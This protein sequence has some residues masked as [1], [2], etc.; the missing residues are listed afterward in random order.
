M[1]DTVAPNVQ[2]E[3]VVETDLIK[4]I[5]KDMYAPIMTET[6][7]KTA[8]A[9]TESVVEPE[10][11]N[12]PIE[13]VDTPVP[14]EDEKQEEEQDEEHEEE[15]EEQ[16]PNVPKNRDERLPCEIK[17]AASLL[18]LVYLFRLFIAACQLMQCGKGNISIKDL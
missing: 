11:S 12:T 17:C 7:A 5:L 18:A 14:S 10:T 1:S 9:A 3:Q 2:S 13:A 8:T 6:P 16:W 15:E 4:R